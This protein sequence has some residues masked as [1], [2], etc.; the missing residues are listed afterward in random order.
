M[1]FL[2]TLFLPVFVLSA[3]A[4]VELGSHIAKSIGSYAQTPDKV[5][6]FKVG[7]PYRIKGRLYKPSEQYSGTEYGVASWY[8]PNFHG[9][10]TANGEI[11]N[12]N[13]L[14]A[15]H[16]TLQM[17][18]IVRVTN[19]GNGRSIIL[20]VNDRGPFA[21]DRVIDVSEKAAEVLGF[22]NAGTAK[23]RIDVLGDQSRQVANAARDGLS[24]R[25]SEIAF[26]KNRDFILTSNT[27]KPSSKPYSNVSNVNRVLFDQEKVT[28]LPISESKQVLTNGQFDNMLAQRV[29]A[30]RKIVPISSISNSYI[31]QVGA[32]A[33]EDNAFTLKNALYDIDAP[34]NIYRASDNDE[35]MYRVQIGPFETM[36]D[37]NRI[38]SLLESKGRDAKIITTQN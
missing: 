32:F 30:D 22:K 1:R 34:I 5:G 26:N 24:T 35:I 8:G 16:R 21:H 18:S 17:P 7:N 14:T 25:G 37:A 19:M 9:K 29:L 27:P 23:V 10:L 38:S 12:R 4:Q 31:V 28:V 20:R 33:R 36:S 11:F 2:F 13:E 3:C 6:S 15:A